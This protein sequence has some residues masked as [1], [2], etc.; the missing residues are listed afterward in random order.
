MNSVLLLLRVLHA[1]VVSAHRLWTATKHGKPMD[2][3]RAHGKPVDCA[4]R[5]GRQGTCLPAHRLSTGPQGAPA[6]RACPQ[7]SHAFWLGRQQAF[8]RSG[9]P[10]PGKAISSIFGFMKK[11]NDTAANQV[12]SGTTLDRSPRGGGFGRAPPFLPPSARRNAYWIELTEKNGH[13]FRS[14]SGLLLGRLT[15]IVRARP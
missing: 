9:C 3:T 5:T 7:V 10:Q 1:L 13:N 12:W 2:C 6:L 4:T 8:S 15:L 14:S 11:G